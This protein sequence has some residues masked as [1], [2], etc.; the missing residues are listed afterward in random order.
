MKTEP[1]P[2]A[3]NFQGNVTHLLEHGLPPGSKFVLVTLTPDAEKT[4]AEAVQA[5]IISNVTD[6][7]LVSMLL[8]QITARIGISGADGKFFGTEDDEK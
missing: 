2:E 1:F 7:R 4:D 5:A 8:L 3:L 6:H